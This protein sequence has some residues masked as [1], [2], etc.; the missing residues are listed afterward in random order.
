MADLL[1]GLISAAVI[2]GLEVDP[3]CK[4]WGRLFRLPMVRRA[5]DGKPAHQSNTQAYFRMS[6]G[7]VDFDAQESAPPQV[8]MFPSTAFRGLSEYTSGEFAHSPAARRLA[9]KLGGR[10][11]SVA[12]PATSTI[13]DVVV[14]DVPTPGEVQKYTKTS[15]GGLSRHQV[16]MKMRATRGVGKH[17][18]LGKVNPF[19][20]APAVC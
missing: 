11:G 20:M 7:R 4:D 19:C 6:W 1:G 2:A 16:R 14:G 5:D 12:R 9:E 3:I 8:M 10:I 13:G 18:S 17:H 15:N